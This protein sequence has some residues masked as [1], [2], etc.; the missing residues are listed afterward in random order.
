MDIDTWHVHRVYS[1]RGCY[2]CCGKVMLD[3]CLCCYGGGYVGAALVLVG[4]A[5]NI[6]FPRSGVEKVI[7]H[8]SFVSYD[9]SILLLGLVCQWL[10]LLGTHRFLF[11]HDFRVEAY[12][13]FWEDVG[14]GEVHPCSAI[15][16]LKDVGGEL[17]RQDGQETSRQDVDGVLICKLGFLV[18]NFVVI[19]LTVIVIREKAVEAG[20]H[21]PPPFTWQSFL[22][23]LLSRRGHLG[24]LVLV[25]V[26]GSMDLHVGFGVSRLSTPWGLRWRGWWPLFP[27]GS[28]WCL[29]HSV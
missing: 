3:P 14:G 6:L 11:P 13:W 22:F 24:F 23:F 5:R 12:N 27:F 19:T 1:I 29:Y 2:H 25:K 21:T 9:L 17:V 15:W 4:H 20:V 8:T 28:F 16:V 10:A 18:G 7:D 26:P